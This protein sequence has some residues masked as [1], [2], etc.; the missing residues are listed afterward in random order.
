MWSTH[1]MTRRGMVD[2]LI[3]II[4]SPRLSITTQKEG[5]RR[6]II[7]HLRQPLVAESY[8]LPFAI[9]YGISK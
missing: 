4:I 5:R 3:E 9:T 1:S 7:S 6:R 8:I 2:L